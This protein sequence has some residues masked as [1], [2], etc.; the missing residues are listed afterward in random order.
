MKNLLTI[1]VLTGLLAVAASAVT[2]DYK[3]NPNLD[4]IK[5]NIQWVC[6]TDEEYCLSYVEYED[7]LLQVNPAP[8]EVFGV[9]VVDKFQVN[10]GHV[11]VHFTEKNLRADT[12]FTFGVKC[13][14][15]TLE[16]TITPTYR[17]LYQ[18]Q[19]QAVRWKDSTKFI[20]T[21]I[22]VLLLALVVIYIIIR[23]IGG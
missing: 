12:N 11:K 15:E 23:I 21:G 16:A 18:V 8:E 1:L 20:V 13:G 3:D 14:D 22:I 4:L 5:S 6:Q 10:N 7:R 17:D 9:G 2:C 19:D